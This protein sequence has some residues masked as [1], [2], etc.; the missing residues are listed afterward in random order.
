MNHNIENITIFEHQA[1]K[2][3]QV[4][5]TDQ[6]AVEFTNDHLKLLER[7]R[8][9]NEDEYFPYYSLIHNGVKFKSYVGVI[10]VG[11]LQ[12]EV[13]PKTDYSKG[14]ES[15]WR[16]HLLTMLKAVYKLQAQ[17]P[18][19]AT[20]TLKSSPILDVFLQR[21]LNEVETL[22]HLG[23]IKTY[24]KEIGNRNALKGKLLMNKQITKNNVHKERFYLSY[25]AYDH[26]HL[27]NRI[28]YKTLQ[29]IPNVTG[30]T[31]I[32]NRAKTLRFEFPELNDLVVSDA[33]FNGL[34]FD[35]K[36]E[37]YKDAIKIAKLILLNYMPDRLNRRNS[38]LALMFDMNRLWEEYVYVILRR[39]LDN[40]EVS[41]QKSKSFWENKTIRP[42]IVISSKG[43]KDKPL[44]IIDTK[45]K[46]P[47]DG[48]PG[49]A[50][51]KQMYVYHKYWNVN[52]TVL[53]YPDTNNREKVSGIFHDPD[54]NSNLCCQMIF[55][56]IH[57]FESSIQKIISQILASL[58]DA[59][60]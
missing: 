27:C 40:Y 22:L 23:L 34:R 59:W 55:V 5:E 36:S 7:F 43:K 6:N 54:G 30:N 26:N 2:V 52:K 29:M 53:L 45:W 51:L 46:C 41:A 58:K 28:L 12:I 14:D 32:A 13:L 38:V 33:L 48:R 19:D 21:F 3:W 17:S 56:P 35:R 18:S 57:D 20:Q 37:V 25:S 1:I 8:G 60:E 24:R 47:K 15:K 49:D 44:L 11:G 31:F 50:D 16:D 4:F 39:K 9:D 42:D 10:S